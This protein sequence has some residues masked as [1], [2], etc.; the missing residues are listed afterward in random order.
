MIPKAET[1]GMGISTLCWLPSDKK[2]LI[3]NG[4]DEGDEN[5]RVVD[6]LATTHWE[7][8]VTIVT[9]NMVPPEFILAENKHITAFLG[10]ILCPIWYYWKV[11]M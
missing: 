8:L 5:R 9:V 10:T 11:S 2:E 6:H 4:K 7:R 3:E 1:S